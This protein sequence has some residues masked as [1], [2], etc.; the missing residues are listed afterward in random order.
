MWF[1]WS[2]PLSARQLT[3]E[4]IFKSVT[5][6]PEPS[7]TILDKSTKTLESISKVPGASF[8]CTLLL[9]QVL[10]SRLNHHL[11]LHE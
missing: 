4:V 5:V 7:I 11:R 1:S 6:S 9:S 8:K 3:L 10:N 2:V